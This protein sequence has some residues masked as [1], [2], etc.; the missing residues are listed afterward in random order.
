MKNFIISTCWITIL[1]VFSV[2]A[3]TSSG[4]RDIKANEKNKKISAKCHVVLIDGSEVVIFNR[5]QS[6]KLNK[7]ARKVEG[8]KV[9]TPKSLDKIQVYRAFQCVL[10]DEDFTN[11]KARAIDEK[12]AR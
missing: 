8:K 2:Q 10:A 11:P 6:D 12:T 7:L 4:E 5:V 1:F 9:S 3:A